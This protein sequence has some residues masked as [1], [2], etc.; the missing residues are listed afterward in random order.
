ME[1]KSAVKLMIQVTFRAKVRQSKT[2]E[3]GQSQHL[4]K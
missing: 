4:V 1:V 2:A 3:S